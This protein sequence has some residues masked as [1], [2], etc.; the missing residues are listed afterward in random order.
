MGW[1]QRDMVRRF[2]RRHPGVVPDVVYGVQGFTKDG[3]PAWGC[4]GSA[5]EAMRWYEESGGVPESA[6]MTATPNTE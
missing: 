1:L 5:E 3:Y 2:R 6:N 4:G